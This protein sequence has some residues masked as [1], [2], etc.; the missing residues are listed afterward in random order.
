MSDKTVYH[1]CSLD[2]FQKIIENK[3]LWLTDVSKSNDSMETKWFQNKCCQVIHDFI[4]AMNLTKENFNDDFEDRIK[5]ILYDK[6]YLFVSTSFS[7]I[8]DLLSQWRGY[9]DDGYGLSIGINEE[10][11][12]NI[13]LYVEKELKSAE[14]EA[15]FLKYD[16]VE[17]DEKIQEKI[18]SLMIANRIK[19]CQ[20]KYISRILKEVA[21]DCLEKTV[22][23]KNHAFKEEKESRLAFT[24]PYYDE[25]LIRCV[26][27]MPC[28]EDLK[29]SKLKYYNNR[30]N[31]IP[32]VELDFKKCKNFIT[33]IGIGPKSQL[34]EKD[35]KLFLYNNEL[36][37]SINDEKIKVFKSKSTYR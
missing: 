16:V 21:L 12:L 28:S 32:Y 14:I 13:N 35:I 29:I 37:D 34:I 9:A 7:R 22:F 5:E 10:K 2:V 1:Y 18:I 19:N 23:Y 25:K 30:K 11:L 6:H 3:T 33:E 20:G 15:N 27:D 31:L 17:Y 26:D 8:G 36:I 4:E 24:L